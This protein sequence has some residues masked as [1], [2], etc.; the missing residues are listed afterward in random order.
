MRK[1]RDT[2]EIKSGAR[3][4]APSSRQ[5]W[6]SLT[7]CLKEDKSATYPDD[8]APGN[9]EISIEPGVPNATAVRFDAHLDVGRA[10]SVRDRLHL[11]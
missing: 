1:E 3:R 6:R 5:A 10:A 7:R 8:D 9:A 2:R 11:E 4:E